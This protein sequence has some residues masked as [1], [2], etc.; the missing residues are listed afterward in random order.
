MTANITSEQ[1]KKAWQA[2]SILRRLQMQ[3]KDLADNEYF[4]ATV[5][6][7]NGRY[8]ALYKQWVSQ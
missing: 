6:T 3:R 7:A 8:Q 5:E 1:V 4:A 2:Y